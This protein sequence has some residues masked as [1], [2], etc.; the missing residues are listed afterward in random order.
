MASI[1]YYNTYALSG[2]D[3]QNTLQV[4]MSYSSG[5]GY[6]TVNSITVYVT[7]ST[8]S[9]ANS[10]YNYTVE[11][12]DGAIWHTGTLALSTNS[13]WGG[14]YSGQTFTVN[15]S[16]EGSGIN[17][18]N[19]SYVQILG[20]GVW[21]NFLVRGITCQV[22]YTP[23]VACGAPTSVTGG[24]TSAVPGQNYNISW[25]GATAGSGISTYHIYRNGVY[26]AEDS[27][28]PYSAAAPTAGN[29]YV[30][31]IKT[32]SSVGSTYDSPES[33]ASTTLTSPAADA[34]AAPANPTSAT[35]IAEGAGN[36]TFSWS[37][38]SN[39]TGN[40]VQGY[41]A[42]HNTNGGTWTALAQTTNTSV[43]VAQA[44]GGSYKQFRVKAIGSAS[45]SDYSTTTSTTTYRAVTPPSAAP[46][47]DANNIA[48]G[49]N[50][51]LR[52]TGGSSYSENPIA[53]YLIYQDGVLWQTVAS[54]VTSYTVT[55][56]ATPS[57]T[58]IYKIGV[59][60]ARGDTSST[61]SPTVTLTTQNAT[62][63]PVPTNVKVGGTATLYVTGTAD[64]TLTWTIPTPS[65]GQAAVS[66][67]NVY[68]GA[69]KVTATPLGA[70]VNSYTLTNAAGNIPAAG[71]NLSFTV[72]TV[73]SPAG[74]DSG[75][76]T[77]AVIYRYGVPSAPSVVT[78]NSVTGNLYIGETNKPTVKLAWQGAAAGTYSTI[79]GYQVFDGAGQVGSNIVTTNSYGEVTVPNTAEATYYVKTID[80]SGLI[81]GNS[82]SRT[83]NIV[84]SG[85][86]SAPT[87]VSPPTGVTYGS[88]AFNWSAVTNANS[89]AIRYLLGYKT[90]GST[91]ALVGEYDVLSYNFDINSNVAAGAYYEFALKTRAYFNGD[92][93][94]D[95]A[96]RYSNGSSDLT[97]R[98]NTVAAPV[99]NELKD[100]SA[101]G[102]TTY[103]YNSV[104]IKFTHTKSTRAAPIKFI[105]VYYR[106]TPTGDFIV[107][108]IFTQNTPTDAT[109]YTISPLHD[110]SLFGAGVIYYKVEATDEYNQTGFIT[111]SITK[112]A[113]PVISGVTFTNS[114]TPN[115]TTSLVFTPNY[116]TT[117]RPLK[118]TVNF[119]YS[120]Q[121]Y[122]IATNTGISQAN[123]AG[124]TPI[125]V[126]PNMS[127]A[128]ITALSTLRDEI[129]ANKV[130]PT[131]TYQIIVSDNQAIPVVGNSVT[132]QT[133]Y[134]GNYKTKPVLNNTLELINGNNGIAYVNSGDTLR[135]SKG[136]IG[137]TWNNVAGNTTG[138]AL[139]YTII[140][141]N[142]NVFTYNQ[143]EWNAFTTKDI[144]VE[145]ITSD[146]ELPIT[147]TVTQNYDGSTSVSDPIVS[148]IWA[149]RFITPKITFFNFFRTADQVFTTSIGLSDPH[150]GGSSTVANVTAITAITVVAGTS[151][152]TAA[153]TL[154]Q[155]VDTGSPYV[156]TG[157]PISSKDDVTV[158]ASATLTLS[159]G[160]TIAISSVPFLLKSLGVVM[161]LRKARVGINVAPDGFIDGANLPSLVVEGRTDDTN[162]AVLKLTAGT[163][164]TTGTAILFTHNLT[165]GVFS[166]NEVSG[167]LFSLNKNL[168][169]NNGTDTI[170]DIISADTGAS[171]IN[172]I[173]ATQGTGVIYVGQS[174]SYGGGIFYAGDAISTFT[175]TGLT[176]DKVA[177]FARSANVNTVV[178]DWSNTGGAIDFKTTPTVNT[179]AVSL[180]GHSHSTFDRATS[181]LT[182]ANVFSDIVVTDGI[183]TAISTRALTASDLGLVATTFNVT[184][185]AA[186]WTTGS[187]T[188]S[189]AALTATSNQEIFPATTIT[190]AQLKAL[191]KAQVIGSSQGAGSCT[192]KALGTVPTIDIPVTVIVRGY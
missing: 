167:G 104:H 136:T 79:S 123:G 30:F 86:L 41:V 84:T 101:S 130:T 99:I 187:Y 146:R 181:E 74:Y 94:T 60:G 69:T 157:L 126:S 72:R 92:S 8:G 154:A 7:A 182:G 68:R 114:N 53:N 45:N 57:G 175:A 173:G 63:A 174:A 156:K 112:I 25:S 14:N 150:K 88:T 113:A 161:A 134:V 3:V 118:Y 91:T 163:G 17:F 48:G 177:L 103:T 120:G 127:Y 28:S 132:Y 70:A 107:T 119:I 78:L 29:S 180:V 145:T 51:T 85:E 185:A 46:T 81:S 32:I 38:V 110:V 143:T 23:Y 10:Y 135:I 36:V 153:P 19:I 52:W 62:S 140:D 71:A 40:T 95:S 56:S 148:K 106:T 117:E 115:T 13:Q 76:S 133:T 179:T 73:S 65:A 34:L 5:S 183:T 82:T 66:G 83:L 189:N 61:Q 20:T 49:T 147:F 37:A 77:Q 188:I 129:L 166:F 191:Q 6:G 50:T 131:I 59:K 18:N 190:L 21:K 64:Q 102:N 158:N 138:Q 96:Y 93:Y 4:P 105:K 97:W 26:L 43:T 151:N 12:W 155:L 80:S 35:Y 108:P 168:R 1:S 128:S 90:G 144:T 98:A 116:N 165:N 67:F 139:T 44:A 121:T 172:L 27:T 89:S 169:I 54:T 9:A 149:R 186:S 192:I 122:A 22:D 137:I 11:V 31:T 33:S 141:H 58:K 111:G 125:T 164:N 178:A 16:N 124:S 176:I 159:S 55:A 47:L 42:E 15:I 2:V 109:A 142:N 170:V 75:D 152:A 162:V 171:I 24:T 87:F 100:N 160:R 184:L 39:V